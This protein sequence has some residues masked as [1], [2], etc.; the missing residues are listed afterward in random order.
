MPFVLRDYQ[1][2]LV[3]RTREA[4]AAGDRGVIL[5]A[6]TGAGKTAMAAH[7]LHA[8]VERGKSAWMLCH[9]RELLDQITAAMRFEGCQHYVTSA[10]W[11]RMPGET[12][13]RGVMI[14]SIPTIARRLGKL[15]RPDFIVYDEAHHIAA[16]SWSS[17]IQAHPQAHHLG[18][19]AT[20]IRGDGTGLGKY[21]STLIH[22]PQTRD[23][24][25]LGALAPYR[26]Y[27]PPGIDMRGVHVRMGEFVA[28]EAQARVAKLTGDV[29]LHYRRLAM[30]KQ[31]LVFCVSRQHS[32]DVVAAFNAAGIEA[33]HVD[34]ETDD[35]VRR[36]AVED[37]RKGR[38][39]V[40]SNVDLFGEGVDL[41][42]VEALYM[43]RPTMSKSLYLQQIGRVLRPMPGKTALIFD[44]VANCELHGLP[45]AL[46]EWTLDGVTQQKSGPTERLIRVRVCPE[47]F[48][49]QIPA[50]ACKYCGHPF[51]VKGRHIDMVDGELVEI[52]EPLPPRQPWGNETQLRQMYASK[53]MRPEIATALARKQMARR[54]TANAA[55]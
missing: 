21:F 4:F 27:A 15:G 42:G 24:I 33:R 39:K 46:R 32:R 18:L 45:D 40:L 28:A 12:P 13:D 47:C 52:I 55:G 36:M 35:T 14:G 2:A 29:V 51:E 11:S 25:A 3:R 41:P 54:E 7:I 8:S 48:S 10:G 20:P 31:A 23:L 53:G 19:S 9:R 5:Q 6:P 43:L 49:A 16:Q 26:L 44:H 1:D 34:G 50:L 38:L 22:G 17:I 30:G 37:F